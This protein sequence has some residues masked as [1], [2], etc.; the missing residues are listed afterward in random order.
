[1][2]RRAMEVDFYLSDVHVGDFGDISEE[3]KYSITYCEWV[4]F[5]NFFSGHYLIEVCPLSKPKKRQY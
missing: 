1:M 5:T 2:M 3:V 4:T